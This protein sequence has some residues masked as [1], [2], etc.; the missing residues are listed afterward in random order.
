V[1]GNSLLVNNAM[2]VRLRQRDGAHWLP[3]LI[4]RLDVETGEDFL[5]AALSD[6]FEPAERVMMFLALRLMGLVFSENLLRR[7]ERACQERST[8]AHVRAQAARCL[9]HWSDEPTILLKTLLDDSE[10]LEVRIAVAHEFRE[11]ERL[12]DL[13][14]EALET[15]AVSDEQPTELRGVALETLGEV[16]RGLETVAKLLCSP[17]N[18]L[19]FWAAFALGEFR[20]R[21]RPYLERL[22]MML[23]QETQIGDFGTIAEKARDSIRMISMPD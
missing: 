17:N 13:T 7:V 16:K 22:G 12:E 2:L 18:E 1:L 14:V 15:I 4:D 20:S 6:E 19:R 3:P 21:A 8:D 11:L 9:V 10:V 5:D 23:D